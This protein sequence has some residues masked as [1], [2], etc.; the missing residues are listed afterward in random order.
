VIVGRCLRGALALAVAAVLGVGA[1]AV[2]WG[3][4]DVVPTLSGEITNFQVSP[5]IGSASFTCSTATNGS[6]S[7]HAIGTAEGP[8]PG[9]AEES[10]TFTFQ[11]GMI[12]SYHA[13]FTI[14]SGP[15]H[16]E[17]T[18]D[19]APEIGSSGFCQQFPEF[20][21]LG[22]RLSA[23]YVATITSPV[24]TRSDRGQSPFTFVMA[25]LL[26]GV[27][28][29]NM[30]AE[31]ASDREQSHLEVAPTESVNTVG[32]THTVTVIV[33]DAQL[34]PIANAH[35]LITVEGSVS[36]TGECTTG[37][38]GTCQF[39]YSGP[40]EPGADLL[41]ACYDF[42]DDGTVDPG[43]K[44]ATAMKAWNEPASTPG[45]VSGGGFITTP[46]GN[47]VVFGFG[48]HA[49]EDGAQGSCNVIDATSNVRI[50]CLGVSLVVILGTHAT[51]SGEAVQNGI[52]TNY[53]ID[54][55]DLGDPGAGADTFTIQTDSG[56]AA[57]GTLDAGN[58]RVNPS[59]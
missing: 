35:I 27:T 11:D 5:P 57:T 21:Q 38:D 18:K 43:E 19:L 16:I 39:T 6:G 2:A 7:Y 31:Y 47:R 42:D 24:G 51:I 50:R 34:V 59:S 53:T 58:I 4:T 32:T 25:R 9:T 44:C 46:T 3:D 41:T 54:V 15:T 36:V 55:D 12:T 52:V 37:A 8:Y 13:S 17:G 20:E 23:R 1:G 28:L 49:T 48:A 10:G 56:Y 29:A 40:A 30:Q 45:S 33:S 26:S 22:V 14:E